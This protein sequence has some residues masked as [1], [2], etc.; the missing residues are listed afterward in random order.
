VTSAP[1]PAPFC[2][3]VTIDNRNATPT[4]V[5]LDSKIRA[6]TRPSA[7]VS[8]CFFSIG[9]STMAVAIPASQANEIAVRDLHLCPLDAPIPL[10]GSRERVIGQGPGH[11]TQCAPV[12]AKWIVL[13]RC[14]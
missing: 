10:S 3:N 12:H 7:N 2:L 6:A 8:F 5:V 4:K 11:C 9:N 1:A 13:G 14:R